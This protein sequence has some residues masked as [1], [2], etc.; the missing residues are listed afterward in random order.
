MKV[1]GRKGQQKSSNAEFVTPESYETGSWEALNDY[2]RLQASL[3][4]QLEP[5]P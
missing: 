5:T 2:A 1:L 3:D 4:F